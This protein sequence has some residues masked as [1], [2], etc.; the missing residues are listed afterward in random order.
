MQRCTGLR[1]DWSRR[2]ASGMPDCCPA[3]WR[4]TLAVSRF[5]SPAEQRYA[6]I[7][8]EALALAWGLE[9]TRYFMQVC[10]NLVVVTISPW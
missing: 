8:G 10:D 7:E 9:Q 2:G 6:A 3:G 4:I 5:L 1:P